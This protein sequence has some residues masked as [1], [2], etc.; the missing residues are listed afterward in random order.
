M[1]STNVGSIHYDL[2]LNTDAFSKA[3]DK[4][5][6]SLARVGKTI[7]IGF[8]AITASAV[9][10]GVSAV[11]A[12]AEAEVS[13]KALEHAVIGVSHATQA[14][15]KE[16]SDLAD[17]LEKKGVLD[18]DNIKLGLAQLSTFGLS[19]KAVQ[20]LGGSLA[21]L[22]VNQFGV[23]ASGEQLADSANMIAKALNG[24]FGV[25]EKSG[26]RFT[27]AQK[28]TIQFGTEMQKVD[29]INK[30]FAQNLKFTNE[31]ALTTYS[32][33]LAK[34]KVS[35]G[36][37][38]EKFGQV[39]LDGLSPFTDRLSAFVSS[40]KFTKWVEKTQK[41][42]GE[43][44][45]KAFN[46]LSNVILPILVNILK[47]IVPIFVDL[48]KKLATTIKWLSENTDVVWALVAGF[49][50]LK[51]VLTG[52]GVYTALASLANPVGIIIVGFAILTAGIVY[53][54]VHFKEMSLAM[55]VGLAVLLGP[56]GMAVL[57]FRYL[58]EFVTVVLMPNMGAVMDFFVTKFNWVKD[59][60]WVIVGSII[61]F[62]AT[63]PITLPLLAGE[64]MAKVVSIVAS[65]KW[66][67]VFAS[68][69]W[70]MQDAWD[71]V[72]NTVN[73]AWHYIHDLNWSDL[74]VGVLKSI[75]NALVGMIEGALKTGLKG[76]PGSLENNIKLPRFA[77]GTNNAPAGLALVGERGPELVRMGGG[78]QVF[79]NQQTKG[80]LGG[81][82][83]VSI[84][85]NITIGNKQDADNFFSRLS[86]NIELST[87]GISTMAGTA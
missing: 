51:I 27:E 30:G 40:E 82:S 7:A 78:E 86:R 66:S 16:T 19:N 72:T 8:T 31:V 81:N 83:N 43:N 55:Q 67:E 73:N 17:A 5:G 63:L 45:P 46:Y 84:Y 25:L 11:K 23:N 29:A 70:A 42:V 49:T 58:Y 28:Q 21:D 65:V 26:I 37:I 64:A 2:S 74:M 6:S 71:K 1:S 15:L 39:I 10:M 9:A 61:G 53:L 62:F 38:Q 4:L 41:W 50:A 52:A 60:F 79:T 77:T 48:A 13:S 80:M 54:L 33:K 35:L 87:K 69:W 20:K 12:F 18:G 32:G 14:Q 76:L 24:Q 47:E 36:N 3:S 44:L 57:A 22:A 59:N 68:I 34:M 85:G 56:I 75:G